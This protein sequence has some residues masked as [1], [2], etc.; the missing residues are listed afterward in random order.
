MCYL[1]WEMIL[2]ER[3]SSR[4]LKLCSVVV[5]QCMCFVFRG[6]GIERIFTAFL[7]I[8]CDPGHLVLVL[9]TTDTEE[10]AFR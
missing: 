6:L 2:T 7:K 4:L 3:F 9:N 10:V 1:P 8:Y 5:I